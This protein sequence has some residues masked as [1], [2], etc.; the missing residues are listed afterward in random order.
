M[1]Q[2]NSSPPRTPAKAF[3]RNHAGREVPA[4]L[5]GIYAGLCLYLFLAALNVMSSGL[6][7]FGEASD[8]LTR[9]LRMA[10]TRLL[11]YLAPYW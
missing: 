4:W 6:G 5:R 8:F 1:S 10:K 2:A 7:T 3:T 9:V 11:P